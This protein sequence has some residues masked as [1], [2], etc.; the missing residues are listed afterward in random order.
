M[1]IS[2]ENIA[3]VKTSL[4]G[5]A[6]GAAGAPS[7]G[8]SWGGWVTAGT[9]AKIADRTAVAAWLALA[10]ICVDNF[11][12]EPD[13]GAQLIDL[14][15]SRATI[16]PASSS[17]AAGA[18][19]LGSKQNNSAVTRACAQ[20]LALLTKADLDEQRAPRLTH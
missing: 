4:F 8:F 19:L 12:R 7:S 3:T 16:R 10:P 9:A 2:K 17:R 15:S 13:A 6:A 11:R 18:A 1:R 14:Q 20:S 5:A